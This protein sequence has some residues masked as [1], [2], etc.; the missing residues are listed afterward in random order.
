MAYPQ[1]NFGQTTKTKG[2]GKVM[3]FL[4]LIIY[5]LCSED[6]RGS[7]GIAPL[8]LTLVL[9]QFHAPVALPLKKEHMGLGGLQ[10]WFGRCEDKDCSDGNRN[11]AVNSTACRYTEERNGQFVL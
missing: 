9:D 11:R 2:L 10:S 7:G 3:L 8:F 5:T 6:I 1:R 4:C